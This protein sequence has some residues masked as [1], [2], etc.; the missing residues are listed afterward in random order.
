METFSALVALCARSPMDSPHKGQWRG[1]LMFSLI[2]AWT[3]G[4]ANNRDAGDSMRNRA[5]NGS[6]SIIWTNDLLFTCRWKMWFSTENC[7]TKCYKR[8]V[9]MDS[10]NGCDNDDLFSASTHAF[11]GDNEFIRNV[12]RNHTT[13][14]LSFWKNRKPSQY[15]NF[16][17]IML[18]PMSKKIMREQHW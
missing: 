1:S 9:S 12:V 16:I 18:T 10:G 17:N 15:R 14:R 11:G 13:S 7:F 6:I 8:L 3:N 4:C 2:C 5:C